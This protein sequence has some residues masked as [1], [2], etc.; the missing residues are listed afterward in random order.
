MLALKSHSV[1]LLNPVM[2]YILVVQA[3]MNRR[4]LMV[5]HQV[6]LPRGQERLQT[7]IIMNQAMMCKVGQLLAPRRG[8]ESLESPMSRCQVTRCRVGQ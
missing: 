3:I 8:Q 1:L 4:W 6:A 7:W 2:I 5:D